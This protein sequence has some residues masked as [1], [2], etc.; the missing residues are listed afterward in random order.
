MKEYP[1]RVAFIVSS[2]PSVSET[3]ILRQVTGLIDRG[4]SVDVYARG[5]M[6]DGPVHEDFHRYALHTRTFY[7]PQ[8]PPNPLR[9]IARG[10]SLIA[11]HGYKN[12]AA[13]F[14]AL[15]VFRHGRNALNLRLLFD[16]MPFLGRGPYDIVHVHFGTNG[17]WALNMQSIG[18][19]QGKLVVTFHG[20]DA[21]VW[22]GHAGNG[23]YRELFARAD[24]L[25]TSSQFIAD[26]L[27][28]L[29]AAQQKIMRLPI[30][31]P[32]A[33]LVPVEEP[34]VDCVAPIILTVGRLVEV[35]G[36]VYSIRAFAAVLSRFPKAEYWIVGDGPLRVEL[37]AL[38]N[39]LGVSHNVR[40]LGS[41]T[42][43][44]VA[45][46]YAQAHIFMLAGVVAADGAEE[47]QGLVLLEAQAAGLPV[48]AS[49]VGGIPEGVIDG[50]S[51]FLVPQRDVDAL[52]ER[53]SYLIERP[54]LWPEMG[55]AG[56]AHVEANYDMNK[57]NDQLVELYQR[58]ADAPQ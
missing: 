43:D 5:A 51:G 23:C 6:Q 12:P 50:R 56:R 24:V 8:I 54:Q 9:R 13:L 55:R 26:R 7:I 14:R 36:H 32:L 41:S 48:I 18:V 2:F 27:I 19:L 25:T 52:A 33:R 34:S 31:V 42:A 38:V 29:G 35:K 15:N 16:A 47:G 30:G 10:F 46:L 11:R 22:P 20:Y 28:G 45:R 58:L 49:R 57:L 3:F 39:D 1:L 53:L 4:H 21:N 40:F 17:P 44:E 37:E